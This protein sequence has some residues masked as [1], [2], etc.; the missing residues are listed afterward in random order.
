MKT[1]EVAYFS[2][3]T[4]NSKRAQV[5]HAVSRFA[6]AL[7]LSC[8]AAQLQ[9]N[10]AEDGD[11]TISAANAEINGYTTLSAGAAAGAGTIS[12][13]STANL[14]LPASSGV[15]VGNLP[16]AAGDLLL[17]YQTQELAGGIDTSNSPAFG[18]VTSFGQAGL[19]E[20]VYVRAINGLN[21][22]INVSGDI[23]GPSCTGLQNSYDANA[24]VIRVPQYRSLTVTNGASVVARLWDGLVG[25]VVAADIRPGNSPGPGAG[26]LAINGSGQ[27][28]AN[29]R[30]FRGGALED[31]LFGSGTNNETRYRL[32][33]CEI[34]ARKGESILGWAGTGTAA[35]T[36]ITTAPTGSYVGQAFGRGALA[37]GGG[38]GNEH[39]AGGGGGAN[40]GLGTWTGSGNPDRGAANVFD[41]AWNL[42]VAG[43]AT[44]VSSGGGRG[45]YTW[46][47]ATGLNPRTVA[48]GSASWN[49]NQRRIH[50]GLGGRPLNRRPN[51][52]T[53]DRLYFGGGGGAADQNNNNGG[54]GGRGGGLVFL[55]AHRIRTDVNDAGAEITANGAA[56]EPTNDP[57]NNDGAGGGGG[58]GSVVLLLGPNAP[59]DGSIDIAANGGAGGAQVGNPVGN[60]TQGPGGGGGGG[61]IAYSAGSGAPDRVV[62]GGFNGTSSAPELNVV[63]QSFPPNGA[64]RGAAGE[65][66][67]APARNSAPFACVTDGEGPF[68][69]P[70]TNAWVESRRQDGQIAVSFDVAAEIGNLGYRVYAAQ[71]S[72]SR[73]LL[74]FVPSQAVDSPTPLQY[75]VQLPDSGFDQIYI[76]DVD[77]LGRETL[78]G[79]FSVGSS[80]GERPTSVEYDWTQARQELTALVGRSIGSGDSAYVDVT[81]PGMQL[82]S[83]EDLLA[84][85]VDLSG[86]ASNAIAILGRAGPVARRVRGPVVFGAG[87]TVEFYADPEPGLY[88]AS[89]R[90]LVMVDANLA[91]LIELRD[92]SLTVAAGSAA[93]QWATV[94]Y[95]PQELYNFSSPTADPFHARSLLASGSPRELTQSLRL[96]I[97]LDGSGELLLRVIGGQDW[98]AAVLPDH[99]VEVHLNG[100]LVASERFDGLQAVEIRAA[101]GNLQAGANEVRVRLPLDTGQPQDLVYIDEIALSYWRE[102]ALIEGRFHAAGL[103]ATDTIGDVFFRDGFGDESAPV[104]DVQSARVTVPG[105]ESAE[106]AYLVNAGVV[107]ELDLA[108]RSGL[109]GVGET[110]QLWLSDIDGLHR[111]ALQPAPALQQWSR[112]TAQYWVISHPLFIDSLAPLIALRTS[113]GLSAQVIDVEQ[114]YRQYSAGN[115]DPAAI[116]RF[117]A[118]VAYPQGG[119]HVLLVGGDTFDASGH[120]GSASISFLPTIYTR[121]NRIVAFAPADGL[122]GDV[123]GDFVPEMAVGR[124]PVRTVAEA[125]EAVR[126]LV[127]YNLQSVSDSAL[128]VAGRAD[129]TLGLDFDA[130]LAASFG[131]LLPANWSRLA[132]SSDD[133]ASIADARLAVRDALAAGQSLVSYM[134]H[135]SPG[136]WGFENLLSASNISTLSSSGTQPIVLQFAC[137]TTYFVLPSANSMAHALVLT[138]DRGASAVLGSTVLLDQGSHEAMANALAPLLV[139]GVRLGD[140][141]LSVKQSLSEGYSHFDGTEVLAGTSLIGDPAQRVR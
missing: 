64:T 43:F 99:H 74:E 62:N 65:L 71:P 122:Y 27:I 88:A 67:A 34:G 5:K 2:C 24:Q 1:V 9:A 21:I 77:I 23:D 70:V 113:E 13:I 125:E 20:F 48:P 116:S 110:S 97:P 53:V 105:A 92:A 100:V 55:I 50:G 10:P 12:V 30:G 63:N 58:G 131:D 39:N 89:E 141:M 98:P 16:L 51:G 22:A 61:L 140:A 132:V 124:L 102:P 38:G 44:S 94:R 31:A 135:S 130:A 59:V 139:P 66:I 7:A 35:P 49:G 46:G 138:P 111:P 42:E 91:R 80:Y 108:G 19:Y 83:H 40:A 29:A 107:M 3:E 109:L 96:D 54:G 137:W 117:L 37:N 133:Y 14:A 72:G 75:S 129:A 101:V 4:S 90:Y 11:V 60:E 136:Q 126:K 15:V 93:R 114:I 68:S 17:I 134:G 25:G 78:R 82:F 128:L 87:S 26:L 81:A 120:L 36:C 127:D 33:T 106:R 8:F 118:E 41:P 95:A 104:L 6:I 18:A 47:A 57:D 76:A 123:S 32:G 69:T 52:E 121:A 84:I 73:Q 86:M 119:R 79:P 45:G 28:S 56:G 115:P 112:E 85:G 103:V